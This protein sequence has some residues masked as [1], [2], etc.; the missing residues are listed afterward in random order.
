[1]KKV[2]IHSVPRSGSS[3]L[4]SIFDSHPNVAYRFQPLF[5]YSH[6]GKLSTVSSYLDIE[7]FF[8]QILYTSDNFVLQKS[9]KEDNRVPTFLKKKSTHIIYKEVRYHHILENLLNQ[10]IEIKVLGL[11]RNPFA[12]I[13]SWLNAPKEF[14]IDLD[15]EIQ[16]EW[17]NA[18]MKN[19]NKQ[20]EYNGYNKWKEAC[21]LFLKLKKE[22]P[23]QF[24]LISY[25]HLLSDTVNEVKQLF[26]FC[27]LEYTKQTDD[28]IKQSTASQSSDAYSVFKKKS[29]DTGWKKT[30]PVFIE[31]AIK[32]D[33]EF[34]KLNE[35][36]KWI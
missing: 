21:F 35:I 1:M 28:F 13:N 29:D 18:P 33:E 15:W 19:M 4:G 8:N 24:Y 34:I 14:R 16:K 25:D 9:S 10:E 26:E 6:K 31:N 32:E 23:D 27:N 2:A 5:S 36:F 17:R 7:D 20:E 22:Y 3:W 11:I 12:V 30:L